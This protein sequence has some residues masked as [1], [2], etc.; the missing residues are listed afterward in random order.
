M[1]SLTFFLYFVAVWTHVVVW[2]N[3]DDVLTP[4][5]GPSRPAPVTNQNLPLPVKFRK[6]NEKWKFYYSFQ[7]EANFPLQLTKNHKS[8]PL[9]HW[10]SIFVVVPSFVTLTLLGVT[11]KVPLQQVCE[12]IGLRLPGCVSV[13]SVKKLVQKT[14]LINVIF[15]IIIIINH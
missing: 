9:K 8:L 13:K 11:V 12:G 1:D 10:P 4:Y 3:F 6:I 7:C 15:M 2:A 5:M 14:K